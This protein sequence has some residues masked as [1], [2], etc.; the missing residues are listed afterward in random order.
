L[1]LQ[2]SDLVDAI[3]RLTKID[4][5]RIVKGGRLGNMAG[6]VT[7]AIIGSSS[8]GLLGGLAG[9]Y[10]GGKAAE[11]LN[12]PAT[13]IALAKSKAGLV[14]KAG[15]ILGKSSVPVGNTLNSIGQVASKN[16][17]TA[18]FISNLLAK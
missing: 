7:G 8:G 13:K 15:G 4:G 18:G 12:N 2:R 11:F 5:S 3:K 10:F 9:D 6:S 16:A 1:N 17:R 14:Q